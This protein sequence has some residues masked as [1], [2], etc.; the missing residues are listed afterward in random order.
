MSK[1]GFGYKHSR[2]D[3]QTFELNYKNNKWTIQSSLWDFYRNF[4]LF[5]FDKLL[6]FT[7]KKLAASAENGKILKG[8]DVEWHS[9]T[10]SF[11]DYGDFAIESGWNKVRSWWRI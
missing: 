10:W 3:R 4:E 5:P 6:E 1:S 11:E 9:G 2:R 8:L 7:R